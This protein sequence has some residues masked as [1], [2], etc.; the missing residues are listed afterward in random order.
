MCMTE[1]PELRSGVYA[2]YWGPNYET[3]AEIRAYRTMGA[4][5]VGMS[6]V[7]EAIAAHAAG[8]SVLGL[9]LVTN[10]AAGMGERLDHAEVLATAAA[11]SEKAASTAAR[12][13]TVLAGRREPKA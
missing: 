3:P 1:V 5:L 12:L 2:G 13:T 8:M 9:S 11:R 7:L 4:D 6:T 10:M